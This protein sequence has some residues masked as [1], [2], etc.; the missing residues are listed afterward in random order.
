MIVLKTT[1]QVQIIHV[2]PRLALNS[3]NIDLSITDDIKGDL[4]TNT[5]TSVMKGDYLEI[6]ASIDGLV[7]NRFYTFRINETI[8]N[9]NIYKD[10]IFVTDQVINQKINKTYSIN[11]DQYVEVESNNDYI[12]I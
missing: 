1:D 12:V 5:S 9:K 10:K 8:T 11:K 4:L 6:G 2:I 3:T 7:K